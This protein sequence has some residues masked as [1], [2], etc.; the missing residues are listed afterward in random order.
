[1]HVKDDYILTC[2]D[3]ATVRCWS[4]SKKRLLSCSSTNVYKDGETIVE[5]EMDKKTN[6]FTEAAKSRSVCMS[7]DGK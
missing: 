5:L 3:D 2:S 4:I 7:P 6:D 1:L